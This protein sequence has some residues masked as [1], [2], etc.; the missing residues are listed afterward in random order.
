[1]DPAAGLCYAPFM[2][3][4]RAPR[5]Y[6]GT[7][8][9]KVNQYEAR[10]LAEAWEALGLSR[11]DDPGRADLAVLLTCAVTARAEAESRRLVRNLARETP[12]GARL[13]ATGCAA[14]VSPAALAGLGA[15]VVPDKARLARHPFGPDNAAPRPPEAYP[16]LAVTGYDR[17]RGLLK[18]QDGCSHGCS[19][20]IV[21]AARGPSVSRPLADVLAEAG[22]LLAS[23]RREIGVTGINLGH[24]GRDLSPQRTFWELL[25]A[26]DELLRDEPPGSARLRL[27]SLD[28]DMLTD[29]GLETL[30]R[31]RHVSPHLHVSLQSADPEI[32]TAMGR[33]PDDAWRVSSFVD[34]LS[35][36]WPTLALGCDVL[37]G[38]PG[39][40]EAAF[41]ATAA[42]LDALPLTYAHVFPY[43][44]RPGTR[45]ASLPGQVAKPVQAERA[46]RLRELAEA[47]SRR[48]LDRLSRAPR[49]EVALERADPSVGACGEYVDCRFEEPV[50][51]PFGTIVAARPVGADGR[52]LRVLPLPG[53]TRP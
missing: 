41:E 11:T 15:V 38:F 51:A 2:R 50:A 18:V 4:D 49:V 29:A 47:K 6:L 5:F 27:G 23:G 7:L 44:R 32:L 21:P 13:V 37:T 33:R 26:L 40:S 25:A 35:L 22:R 17:A 20:C 52:M 24:W 45:A 48:F 3:N 43:S 39:E 30:R 46:R 53:G 14:A 36:E 42:F 31:C 16:G 19:Y 1:M 8:G 28:P 34:R 12:D 10:A 9:C